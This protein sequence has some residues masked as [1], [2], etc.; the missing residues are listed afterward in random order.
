MNIDNN[1]PIRLAI[2]LID[3]VNRYCPKLIPED[4]PISVTAN[5]YFPSLLGI[6]PEDCVAVFIDE[7]LY[8]EFTNGTIIHLSNKHGTIV[9]ELRVLDRTS[10][11]FCQIDFDPNSEHTKLHYHRQHAY[12][13]DK[14]NKNYQYI[15]D[16]YNE[17]RRILD[18][19]E[20]MDTD[21]ATN[22]SS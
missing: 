21:L 12:R 2:P 9:W 11:A 10:T 17:E 1:T 14:D 8:L 3:F 22:I 4:E 6:E 18:E 5:F 16:V 13:V 19:Y 20:K 15:K 7:C